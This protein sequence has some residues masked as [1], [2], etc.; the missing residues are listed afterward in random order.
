[1]NLNRLEHPKLHKIKEKYFQFATFEQFENKLINLS[2]DDDSKGEIFEVYIEAFLK[3]TKLFNIKNVYSSQRNFPSDLFSKLEIPRTDK[4]IDGIIIDT[5][6]NI[7]PYQVKFRSS[8]KLSYEELQGF[9]DQSSRANQKILFTNCNFIAEEYFKR[10]NNI[11]FRGVDFHNLTKNE[12]GKINNIFKNKNLLKKTDKKIDNYQLKAIENI[13]NDLKNNDRTTCLMACGT[14]KTY[15]ALWLIERLLPKRIIVFVPSIALLKQIRGDWLSNTSLENL[16]S[17]AV[18][19][20][21]TEP[22]LYDQ[23]KLNK[24]DLNFKI[25]TDPKEIRK[26]LQKKDNSTKIIFTTYHSSEAVSKACKG[27]SFDIGIFDEAHRTTNFSLKH[28]ETKFNMGLLNKNILIKKRVFFTATQKSY[29][30][31]IV[32]E[33]GNPKIKF[34]MNNPDIYGNVC[35]RLNFYEA[36]KLGAISDY[37]IVI[38]GTESSELTEE[39]RKRSVTYVKKNKI[40]TDQI[41]HQV[42]IKKSIQKFNLS[43]IFTFHS[44]IPQTKSFAKKNK[45]NTDISHLL[46]NFYTNYIEA[47]MKTTE[48]EEIINKFKKSEK[49][50]ISNARCLIEG[51]DVPEVDAIAY[52]SPKKSKIDI[53]QSLGRAVRNRHNQNKKYGY[54]LVP[55]FKEKFR[56]EKIT[57]ATKRSN[58]ETIS[59]VLDA[60]R[61]QDDNLDLLLNEANRNHKRGHGY[62]SKTVEKL[63]EKIIFLENEINIKNLKKH[64]FIKV[65]ETFRNNWDDMCGLLNKYKDQ[66]GHCDVPLNAKGEY[67]ELA[68]WVHNIRLTRRRRKSNTLSEKNIDDLNKLNF[69]WKFSDETLEYPTNFKTKGEIYKLYNIAYKHRIWDIVKPKGKVY[70]GEAGTYTDVYDLDENII[71]EALKFD[72][73]EKEIDKNKIT[74]I[75]KAL[76]YTRKFSMLRDFHR[77]IYSEYLKKEGFIVKKYYS[78]D[79]KIVPFINI[80]YDKFTKYLKKNKILHHSEFKNYFSTKEIW[81]NCEIYNIKRKPDYFALEIFPSGKKNKIRLRPYYEKKHFLKIKKN[82]LI[83]RKCKKDKSLIQF[84]SKYKYKNYKAST[85]KQFIKRYSTLIR[86]YKNVKTNNANFYFYKIKNYEHFKNAI[87][88]DRTIYNEKKNNQKLRTYYGGYIKIKG[89]KTNFDL[90]HRRDPLNKIIKEIKTEHVPLYQKEKKIFKIINKDLF[91]TLILNLKKRVTLSYRE[92]ENLKKSESK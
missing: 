83:A 38:S 70:S 22:K 90:I 5:E 24:K 60:L 67:K 2:I 21:K 25:D 8:R 58:Y 56:G 87:D 40:I 79:G 45:F 46:P 23:I 33:Y 80:E 52:V 9:K 88:I 37:R 20:D 27:I 57:E 11:A 91:E 29:N 14:G 89:K 81:E 69:V 19:S 44:R 48:R 18:C 50:L 66:Y 62:F 53:V 86:F 49:G 12:I 32:D 17:F 75:S 28:Q 1:M 71:R 55:I 73:Y 77:D 68:V 15:V 26:F 4:G 85:D 16:T 13:I 42:A 74:T 3:T 72:F 34:N 51:V 63:S 30:S 43:K 59:E 82:I 47:K 64:I 92:L 10:G 76:S 36:Q 41:A 6:N 35:F 84:G 39:L 54:I 7:I 78:K 31:K 65:L 61:E